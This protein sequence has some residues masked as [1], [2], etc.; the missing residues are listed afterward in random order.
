MIRFRPATLAVA[1]L[2]LIVIAGCGRNTV[3]VKGRLVKNGQ[4]YQINI[5]GTQPDTMSVDFIGTID[6]VT[7]LIPARFEPDG[8]SFRVVGADGRGIRPGQY[9]IAVLHSGYMGEGGDRFSERFSA[10]KTPLTLEVTKD[11]DITIDVGQGT[12]TAN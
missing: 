11:L 1:G 8:S 10:A 12:V 5:Q 3:Q 6:G 9:K 4:P 7:L 2:A